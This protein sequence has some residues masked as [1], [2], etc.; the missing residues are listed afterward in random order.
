MNATL[1][2]LHICS[3][4]IGLMAGFMAMFLRKGSG[5]HG[6]AGSVFA[7][8]ML[9]MGSSGA[10]LAA[11]T[12]RDI[13][14]AIP[15]LL[16]CY[17]VA[18][19]W[20]AARV[21]SSDTRL[22]SAAAAIYAALLGSSTF[23]I[24]VGIVN[25]PKSMRGGIPSSM[26]IVF[27]SIAMNDART[28]V[29]GRLVGTQRIARHLWRMSLVLLLATLSLPRVFPKSVRETNILY[30]PVILVA[31]SMLFWLYRVSRRRRLQQPREN[32]AQSAITPMNAIAARS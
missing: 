24:G 15:G 27:G 32:D 31:G 13:G 17:L 23:F 1:L 12:R 19:G 21:R 4:I 29:R 16:A 30:I 7:V 8:S 2:L 25:I 20:R 9:L 28:L 22:F 26:F 18:T 5:V 11:F 10:Y 3:A 14:N 6:A